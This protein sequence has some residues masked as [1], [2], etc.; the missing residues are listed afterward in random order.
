MVDKKF[1]KKSKNEVVDSIPHTTTFFYA[2]SS[3][4]IKQCFF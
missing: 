4:F 1:T 3:N 2:F